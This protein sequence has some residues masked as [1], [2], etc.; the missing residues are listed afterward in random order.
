MGVIARIRGWIEMV[1]SGLVKEEFKINPIVSADME[2]VIRRCA[3]IYAGNPEWVNEDDGIKTIN[4][5]KAVCSETARLAMLGT[6][7]KI[8]GSARAEW[9]QEQINDVYY[10]I[11]EWI[12]YG[13]AYGTV[14]LKPD[15]DSIEVVTPDRFIVTDCWRCLCVR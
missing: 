13:C 5:A 8:D 11:R 9:L 1:L 2:N 6:S 14:V 15:G 4:F 12:E 10:N 3:D 7:I